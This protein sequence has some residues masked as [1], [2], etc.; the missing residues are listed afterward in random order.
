MTILA[1][2]RSR[3]P[4][5]TYWLALSYPVECEPTQLRDALEAIGRKP[6]TNCPP[7]L[8]GRQ[9]ITISRAGSDLFNGWTDA[10]RGQFPKEGREVL[11]RF[12]LRV[13]HRML[14]GEEI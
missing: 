7:P 11:A 8:N 6:S 10:E 14:Q 3:L 9:K 1:E 12:G 13:G 2:F 4:H 5:R